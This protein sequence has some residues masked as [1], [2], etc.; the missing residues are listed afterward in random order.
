M[1]PKRPHTSSRRGTKRVKTSK[2]TKAV[3]KKEVARQLLASGSTERL[4]HTWDAEV[5]GSGFG[6]DWGRQSQLINLYRLGITPGGESLNFHGYNSKILGFDVILGFSCDAFSEITATELDHGWNNAKYN[7]KVVEVMNP[8]VDTYL[9][10]AGPLADISG[11]ASRD[12]QT[13]SLYRDF[14]PGGTFDTIPE[15]PITSVR[16]AMK[17]RTLY[18]KEVDLRQDFGPAFVSTSTNWQT[19]GGVDPLPPP[20]PQIEGAVVLTHQTTYFGAQRSAYTRFSFPAS[21]LK[22][23]MMPDSQLPSSSLCLIITPRTRSEYV[24]LKMKFR[25]RYQDDSS[26]IV[27]NVNRPAQG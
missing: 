5:G 17:Y 2:S 10:I 8:N 18:N 22:L 4:S 3:V 16:S 25:L 15:F 1:A 9:R 20:A 14:Y 13:A 23:K 27:P 7:I 19:Y 24:S 11:G 6:S 26:T 12:A 21:M